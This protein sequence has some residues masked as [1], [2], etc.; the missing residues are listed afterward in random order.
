MNVKHQNSQKALF[1]EELYNRYSAYAEK[2]HVNQSAFAADL[3]TSQSIVSNYL[4]GERFPTLNHLCA[5]CI[6]LRC[7]PH[8]QRRLFYLGDYEMPDKNGDGDKRNVIIRYYMDYCSE[9]P[10]FTL[11]KC[12]DEL[13]KEGC[14]PLVTKR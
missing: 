13:I 2:A 7:D 11:T 12:E 8:T 6:I 4:T 10:E 1:F 9:R 5:I 14:V 3:G